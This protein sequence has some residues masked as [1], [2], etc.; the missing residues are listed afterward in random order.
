MMRRFST[1]AAALAGV[2]LAGALLPVLA[3][4]S[5]PIVG[6]VNGDGRITSADAL[7][8]Y[9]YLAGRPLPAS[10]DVLRRGDADGD[11]RITR[12]DG[13][14]IMRAAVGQAVADRPVGKP[15]E[16]GTGPAEGV[17]RL[18]CVASVR[19]GTVSCE[20]AA[21]AA[22][23][24]QGDRIAYGGQ[25]VNVSMLT[26]NITVANDTFAFDLRVKNLLGQAIGTND[27]TTVD[28]VKVFVAGDVQNLS[29]N[30][31][32][33]AITMANHD[34]IEPSPF[35]SEPNKFF[36]Y[37]EIIQPGATSSLRRWKI[38]V[39]PGAQ[40]FRFFLYVS[41]PV[42]YPKG[43]VEV[44]PK[45]A[46]ISA[47]GT[48]QLIDTVRNH[49]GRPIGEP[50]TWSSASP[51]IATVS[52]NGLVT[53]V[54]DGVVEITASAGA[55]PMVR[56]PGKMTLTVRTASADSST[57]TANPDTL[58][59]RQSS[60][61]TL[62]LRSASG[63][64]LT[65]SGGTVVFNA[66]GGTLSGF[67][68]NNNGTY[69][70]N[71]T[72]T[73]V[74]TVRVSGTLNGTSFRDTAEVVFTA[75]AATGYRVTSSADSVAAGSPVTI[76]AQTVDADGNAV[77]VAGATVTW[78]STNGGT[79]ASPTSPVGANGAATVVFTTSTTAG[80]THTVT[81]TDAASLTG[82][83]GNIVTRV[84]A[85]T[86]LVFTQQPTDVTAG[87]AITPAVTVAVQDANGNVV[88]GAT[89]SV[90]IA[91]GTNPGGGTLSGTTMVLP[92]NG[93][94]TFSNLSIEKSGTGYT[95][96]AA[97]AGLTGD[98]SSAF[99]VAAGAASQLTVTTQPSDS[100]QSGAQFPQ[101]PS[102]Q[103]R[104]ANGNAV[105]Q[106]GV[107]VTAAIATGGGALGGTT[108][109]NTNASGVATFTDLS[110]A[111]TVGTRTLSFTAASVTPAASSSIYVRAGAASALVFSVQPSNTAAG[112]T[113]T[114]AVQV[115]ITDASGNVVDASSNVT[116]AIGNNPSGGTLAGT[117][118]VAAANGVAT[119]S[120]LSI[121]KSGAA[122]TL[123]ASSGSLT[124]ATSAAFNVTAGAASHATSTITANPTSIVADGAST[125]TITVQLK[126]A[127]GN[128]L[129][130]SGGTVVIATSLGTMS[131][132]TD[133]NDGTYTATL[134]SGTTVANTVQITAT[135]NG[136][137]LANTAT[138]AFTPG[139]AAAYVVDRS[140]NAP[141]AGGTVTI[142][143]QL[144]DANGNA[145]ADGGR[146]VTWSSTNGGSFASPTSTTNSAGLATI[147][148]TT[149]TT[150]GV[151][152]T[153][154]AND[155]TVSGT[156]GSITTQVG[157]AA[158][159][160]F[161][162]QPSNTVAGATIT[163]AVTV[164]IQDANGN[165]VTSSTDGIT[166]AIGNNPSAGT[167]SGSLTVGALNGVATFPNLSIDKSGAGYTLAATSGSLTSATS[168]AFD[169]TPGA[170]TQLTITAQP[171]DTVQNGAAFP[172]QPS[173][174]LRDAN[175]N[176]V[177]QAGVTVTAA[178]ASGGGTLGGTAT[179]STN[180]GGLAVFTD[181]S[182]TGTVGDRTLSF[183]ATGLTGATSSTVY[184]RAGAASQL[185][186]ITQPSD[187]VQSGAAFPQ[188]PSV[189]LRD[190]SGNAVAQSG[191][192]VTAAIASGGGTLGGTATA[193]TNASGVATF[194]N[195]A[196]TGTVGDRTLSFSASGVT[197]ATSSTIHVRAGTPSQLVITTQPSSTAAAGAAFAQQ[198]SV[199]IQDASG[200]AVAQSGV[201]VTAAIASGGGTL[202]GTV[203]A[204][205]DASGTATFTDL[206]IGGT[207]GDR[208]LS[209]SATGLTPATSGTISVTAGAAAALAFTVQ[210]SNVVASAAIT[211]A[212][213][214]SIVD[215]FG[216][217]TASTDNV[218][219][220]IGTNPSGGTLS[221][222]ATVAAVNGVATFS[223]L[224]INLVGTGY[225]LAAS[226]GSLAGATSSAFN[227]THGP[228]HHFLV[229]AAGGG[230][231]GNQL[232]GT[233]FNVRVTAQDEY[234][235]T[236]T[237]FTGT[238]GFTST[239]AGAISA[240]ATSGAFT[241]GV[242]TSHSITFGTPGAFTLTATRT[243]GAESGTSNSFEVQAPPVAVNEGPASNSTPGQPFHAFY[244]TSGNPQTFTL[245]A[246]GVLSNDNLGFPA[247]TITS[248]GADSLGGSVTTYAAGNTVSPLPG[249]GRTT[250]S[251]SVSADGTITFTPPDGFTGNYVFRYRLT[252][253][254]GTSDGQV[255]IAVGVR[256]AASNDTYSPQL[257]GNVPVNTATSTQFR[258]TANDAGDAKVLA[259]T[260][261]SNGTA[262]LNADSTFIFR[263]TAGF[264]NGTASFTYTVTNGF[265]T[266]A[267]ATV[268]MT[269]AD[270][271]IWF[272]NAGA[273]SNGDGRYDSPKNCLVGA[274][275][276]SDVPNDAANDRIFLYAGSYT[277]GL[278]L[279]AGQR[280]IGQRATAPLSSIA[281]VTW[282]ADSGTEP[283]MSSAAALDVTAAAGGTAVTLG[284]GN[285]LR[286]FNF[287]N[288]GA[289]GTALA[290]T[291]F[292]T[293]A[294]SE[295][296]INTNGRAMN[297]TTGTLNGS[298]TGVTSTGGANN[299]ALSGVGTTGTF[300]FGSGALSGAAGDALALTG[301]STGTYTFGGTIA[302][303]TGAA[304]NV[305]GG[306]ATLTLSG[307]VTQ[308]N[309]FALLNVT[310][311]HTGTLAMTGQ[312]SA[313]N[314]TGLQFSDADGTYNLDGVQASSALNGGDAG[315]D[316]LAGSA[317]TFTFG[318]N[319]A[320]TTP[321]GAAVYVSASAPTLAVKGPVTQ[322][323]GK[324]GIYL[325]N[326]TGGTSTFSGL[327]T[328]NTT[329]QNAFEATHTSLAG[330][331]V[332]SNTAN[333]LSTT[334]GTA[335]RI[336]NVNIGPAGLLFRSV[337]AN[338]APNGIVL[339]NTGSAGSLSVTGNGGTCNST[340]ATCTGGTI[341][342]TTG[343]GVSLANTMSPSFTRMKVRNTGAS[344]VNGTA[345]V[346]FAFNDGVIDNSGTTEVAGRQE[347][348]IDFFSNTAPG[349]E[350]NL[351][352]V[353]TIS[354][355][356]LT[357]ARFH[358]VDIGNY[359]G[360]IANLTV[361]NN[362]LTSS[363]SA[364]TSKGTAIRVIAFGGPSNVASVTRATLANN[365]VTNFPSDAG[366]M[367]QGG[368]S[369]AGA[370]VGTYGTPGS[371]TDVI[372]ITGNRIRGA[373]SAVRLG[374]QAILATVN[375]RGQGNFD[376]S[377]NGTVA[378]PITNVTG[379]VISHSVF[380]QA[381]VRTTISGNRI[382][383]NN[384]LSSHGISVGVDSTTAMSTSAVLNLT[385]A[386]N[387]V[388]G[389]NGTGIFALAT[390]Q[391]TLNTRIQNNTVAAP[392][393]ATYGM[394]VIAATA[395]STNSGTVCL[396]ILGNTTAGGSD[397]TDT[398]PG[399]GLRRQSGAFTGPNVLGIVGLSPS[400]AGTPTVENYVNGK[401]TSASGTFGTGGTALFSASS[402]F[403]SCTLSF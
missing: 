347:S 102:V 84:G 33:G 373:S 141:V 281:A 184:V 54:S 263:P 120:D 139:A 76:T 332:A 64:P 103:L 301:A 83:S 172:Q 375:G 136:T 199:Q 61:I 5:N 3:Q 188:Q 48:L 276:F 81:A 192:T 361:S 259:I 147:V 365:V 143:A 163:P 241:A 155:G 326:N 355:N 371:A 399:I 321:S 385:V 293:L 66:D 401:N 215:A 98:T 315:I 236:V 59:V 35:T 104:D 382:V 222:T 160:G 300:S 51:A 239:P 327:L 100:V 21:A 278:T 6:D 201:T 167:L 68:D 387:N 53:G 164:A 267:P 80:V 9:A 8:V 219:V 94:A 264:R 107:T 134:T 254:R 366:I 112:A 342:S 127:N 28:P 384:S 235:N 253:V 279:L 322:N 346:S 237:N 121:D 78:T 113:I 118:T 286:G 269:V 96:A 205:T 65:R 209:F 115:S 274:A 52:S 106:S 174:Q 245:A 311:G 243:A 228:L 343:A 303:G 302:G 46:E 109:A 295:V 158:K 318:S 181:L 221:G 339:S 200:N 168:N 204:L 314:G 265:G 344:G 148:F 395:P 329:T 360:T 97:S 49:L 20:D 316:I 86:K 323:A 144:V 211:P 10:F 282:P 351:S 157:A 400:P 177:T 224:S 230:P 252:N 89:D 225:T 231:I 128:N 210:P 63:A 43:W 244:S 186:I 79:F 328:L 180:A 331:V 290:G 393:D 233:P 283:A 12:A 335:L 324:R 42:V 135:L 56:T 11:G 288:V 238:T 154:T 251:L 130:A 212:V 153:V 58:P 257:V 338:G 23:S 7:A 82:T 356:V 218:T 260:G 129:I 242:L 194:T 285:L 183:S 377:N 368:N 77:S 317:G 95:L 162:Q 386:N 256:P 169:I 312:V 17:M 88:T 131:A 336:N 91:I 284:S 44:Y 357:N 71:L 173:V 306:T 69:T 345:V 27:G 25:H 111:G 175:G 374:T 29:S 22:T 271:A 110:I 234:N 390:R 57:F 381:N 250:G 24:A 87:A 249:T 126:D 190:A 214:V 289:A 50:V 137:G 391:G 396:D 124:G 159:L 62:Q 14:L 13:D 39:A 15:A 223:N 309:N 216:N 74:G 156:S 75:G 36:S 179:A 191:V 125:S 353:V 119:F 337:S 165:V 380:G 240:G 352:G 319:L 176:A 72:S 350:N 292:G 320:I 150:A 383:A 67:T 85:A 226:S 140:D 196:I 248:F 92:V 203:T 308:A 341:E 272:V 145:V 358:G 388:S 132:T 197:G 220:A 376:I 133:N 40:E 16:P 262:T 26:D 146:T 208:T 47:G 189:Q 207:V 378:E 392:S 108:T 280:M 116:L 1:K 261:V 340:A 247:A 31:N 370:P 34:G 362:T 287:G 403:T 193:S 364:A 297:L 246:P 101:Q 32:T 38:H 348:N 270:A 305:G 275:C 299:I 178:I 149:S 398:W 402:G 41:S 55:P 268:S 166:L 185:T 45:T 266:S 255:T 367:F 349:T 4:Q 359:S 122:Y 142:T 161:V 18:R 152:H 73:T 313:T 397:G 187:S 394:Q 258:V 354:G 291:S 195:L 232:A 171:S 229:E 294:I 170:A 60:V 19:S 273:G 330:N 93:V 114:P 99:N 310:G 296:G 369:N 298:V 372:S 90:S 304:V 198:P 2:L 379:H 105:A 277:G 123:A 117:T 213:Q 202:G 307:N 37:P 325:E 389:T 151:V 138:V 30:G 182:I 333:V 70:A 206:S 363:T 227:V 334:T 217:V